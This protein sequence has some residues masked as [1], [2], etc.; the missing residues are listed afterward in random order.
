VR[1]FPHPLDRVS[2]FIDEAFRLEETPRLRPGYVVSNVVSLHGTA[3]VVPNDPAHRS[4][5]IPVQSPFNDVDPV[6]AA[7]NDAI[8]C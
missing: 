8:A 2:C 4:A 1:R 6:L 3:C 7:Y 5:H